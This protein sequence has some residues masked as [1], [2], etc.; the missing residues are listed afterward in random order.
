VGDEKVTVIIT[1]SKDLSE[2]GTTQEVLRSEAAAMVT[3][4]RARYAAKEGAGEGT[5]QA[6]RQEAA[7]EAGNAGK[8]S[9]AGA[10]ATAANG[11][12]AGR[13]GNGQAG[14]DRSGEVR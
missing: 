9:A 11:P 2:I 14:T 3:E 10:A 7:R 12:T 13:A 8:P 1:Y 4:G 6:A 5:Q